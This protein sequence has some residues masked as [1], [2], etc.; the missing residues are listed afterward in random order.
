[1]MDEELFSNVQAITISIS[2]QYQLSVS[3]SRITYL[4]T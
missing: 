4:I 3:V 2:Y 1:M